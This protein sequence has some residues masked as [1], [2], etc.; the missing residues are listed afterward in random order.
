[1]PNGTRFVK[2][3]TADCSFVDERE[4]FQTLTI[5]CRAVP[6]PLRFL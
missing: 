5:S 2:G 6:T 3:Y 1:L 4:R